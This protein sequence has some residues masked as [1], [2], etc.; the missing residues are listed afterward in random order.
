MRASTFRSLRNC[1]LLFCLFAP[2]A[3]MI[4]TAIS[5]YLFETTAYYFQHQ[6]EMPA[7]AELV[8]FRAATADQIQQIQSQHLYFRLWQGASYNNAL[9]VWF[10]SLLFF[11]AAARRQRMRVGAI[12]AFGI[13]LIAVG[14]LMIA[15]TCLLGAFIPRYGLPM[16]Q[17]LLLSLYI[18]VGGTADLFTLVAFKRFARPSIG[19]KQSAGQ[20]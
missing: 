9:V 17:L 12:S 2:S 19:A 7:C 13:T 11:V 1:A 20:R 8:T 6:D 4:V 18:F 3:W 16:R 5:S 10:I 14:L 15:S